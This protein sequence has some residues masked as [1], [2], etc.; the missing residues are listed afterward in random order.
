MASRSNKRSRQL[1]TLSFSDDDW[2]EDLIGRL[3]LAT[4]VLACL[5]LTV[6]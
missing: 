1:L 2:F 6:A 3:F 5:F 4:L